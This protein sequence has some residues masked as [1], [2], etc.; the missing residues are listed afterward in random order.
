MNS[1][2]AAA[3]RTAPST[4]RA[5]GAMN[6]NGNGGGLMAGSSSQS[7][8][9]LGVEGWNMTPGSQAAAAPAA[10][11][12][13]PASAARARSSNRSPVFDGNILTGKHGVNMW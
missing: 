3:M 13:A 1:F 8:S 5:Q 11:A 7:V 12:P 10:P 4:F 9:S 6:N 2:T